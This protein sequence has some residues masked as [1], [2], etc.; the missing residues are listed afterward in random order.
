MPLLSGGAGTP[1]LS[2]G[3]AGCFAVGTG[4]MLTPNTVK[5]GAT[6]AYVQG[7]NKAITTMNKEAG[8]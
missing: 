7:T 6:R 4:R 3:A 2:G 8:R 1:C 5:Q